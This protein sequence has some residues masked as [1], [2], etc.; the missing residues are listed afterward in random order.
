MNSR[1]TNVLLLLNLLLLAGIFVR[2]SIVSCEASAQSSGQNKEQDNQELARLMD[3]DQADRTPP[4]GMEIDWKNVAP[5]DAARLK[6]V[7][8]LYAQ[9]QLHTGNDFFNAALILQHGNTPE[10]YLLA[11]ELAVVAISKKPGL[12]SLAAVTE[13]RF[14]MTIGRPQRFATQYRTE[15]PNQPYRL[16]KVDPAVTD[17][18]RRLM[19]VPSL[20]EAQAR[21]AELNKK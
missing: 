16:Y 20:A 17:E 6:R 1:I 9:N 7:K 13:D 14:L 5:R 19:M 21:E 2:P 15:G 11:H 12:N 4:K 8:E 18:L 3:E 10:D